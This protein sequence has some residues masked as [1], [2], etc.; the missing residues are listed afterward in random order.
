MAVAAE[1][2]PAMGYSLVVLPPLAPGRRLGPDASGSSSCRLSEIRAETMSKRGDHGQPVRQDDRKGG[3]RGFDGHKMVKGRKRQL[4][5]DTL[6]FPVAWRVEP[7]N[8]SDRKGGRYLISGLAPLWPRIETVIA[9]TGY[10]SKK[11]GTFFKDHAGWTLQI[12]KCDTPGFAI[13][14]LN[15]IVERTFAW[16]GRER[17]LSKDYQAKVQTSETIIEIA[18]CRLFLKRLAR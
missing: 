12:V 5:V 6:G 17:R 3:I 15:W 18:A 8:M 16:L 9:D 1:R 10:E 13:V 11:L 14:G 2:F 4:L 7:A